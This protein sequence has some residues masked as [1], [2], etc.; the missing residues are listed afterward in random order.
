[1]L[2]SS[3]KS[4]VELRPEIDEQLYAVDMNTT[5][6]LFLNSWNAATTDPTMAITE[7]EGLIT[8]CIYKWKYFWCLSPMITACRWVLADEVRTRFDVETQS[9]P[10]SSD[11]VR[12]HICMWS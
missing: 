4:A 8:D 12:R 9:K 6:A 7:E 2:A 5:A 1:M 10:F 11:K 3:T